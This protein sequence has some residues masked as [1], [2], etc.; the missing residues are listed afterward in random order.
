MKIYCPRCLQE[1]YYGWLEKH[2]KKIHRQCPLCPRAVVGLTR[3]LQW[4]Y[5][6]Q[7][8]PMI[9]DQIASAPEVQL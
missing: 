9:R 4:H 8:E 6:Q 3:H 2:E 5:W 7:I 1:G